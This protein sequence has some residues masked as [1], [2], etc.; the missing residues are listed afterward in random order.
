MATIH[1]STEVQRS[2]TT[3]NHPLDPL[4]APEIEN[5]IA[6]LRAQQSLGEKVRFESIT[7][8]EPTKDVVL[9]FKEG[10]G[11]TREAFI[12]LSK[13]NPVDNNIRTGHRRSD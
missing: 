2:P 6:I 3:N 5:A 13:R 8:N 7:L 10:D 4:T 12:V 11:V 9:S 1:K